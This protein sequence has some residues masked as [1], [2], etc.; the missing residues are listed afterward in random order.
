MQIQWNIVYKQT[1]NCSASILH[2]TI[3]LSE[4]KVRNDT[5]PELKCRVRIMSFRPA[6]SRATQDE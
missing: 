3:Q 5:H 2:Y 4:G 1:N 6:K